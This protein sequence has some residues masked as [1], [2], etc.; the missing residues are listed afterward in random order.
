M[1]ALAEAI[2]A[3][4][5]ASAVFAD[6]DDE[7]V[8]FMVAGE[9]GLRRAVWTAGS[10][11]GLALG[12]SEQLALR[13]NVPGRA[14]QKTPEEKL[15]EA[16]H[17]I[18]ADHTL[19]DFAEKTHTARYT[20]GD[21]WTIYEIRYHIEGDKALLGDEVEANMTRTP[22]RLLAG[23]DPD[24]AELEP[25]PWD[26]SS[27]PLRL[28]LLGFAMQVPRL[29]P[30]DYAPIE[31]MTWSRAPPANTPSPDGV[32]E[33]ARSQLATVITRRSSRWSGASPNAKR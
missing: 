23:E 10:G 25:G 22:L 7:H 3:K 15:Q 18:G 20:I 2:E 16:L 5:G 1:S 21:D 13:T 14:I 4:F 26:V 19:L 12:P 30:E 31:P 28:P 17:R 27:D 8:F 11:G 33:P 6:V 32:S 29:D 24:Y 9:R